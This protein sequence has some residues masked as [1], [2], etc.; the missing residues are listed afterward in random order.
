MI[1][2]MCPPVAPAGI[3]ADDL[4][5]ANDS[6]VQ[7]ARG[8]WQTRISLGDASAVIVDPGSATA[9]VTD[10]RAMGMDAARRRTAES[11]AA[12]T[13]AGVE[14]LFV[15]ID[16]TMRG[17]VAAQID[18]ALSIWSTVH[19]GAFAVV[20]PAYPA[21]GRTV[22]NGHLL[23]NGAGVE[24]TSVGRDPVTPVTTSDFGELLPGSVNVT[25]D[26]VDALVDELLRLSNAGTCIITV[27]AS[28]PEHLRMIGQAIQR[29]GPRAVPVGSAGLAMVMSVIWGAELFSP[30]EPP[31]AD[32]TTDRVV[33][34]LSSLHDMSR[35]QHADLVA[36]APD[37]ITLAPT[38]AEA[39]GGVGG[40]SR[41]D[42]DSDSDSS[43]SSSSSSSERDVT[44]DIAAWTTAQL[45]DSPSPVVVVLAPAERGALDLATSE[46]VAATLAAI[47]DEVITHHGAGSLV[48]MGGEG[49]R[50]VLDR[51]GA[52][53]IRVTRAIREGIPIGVI[54][55]GR[56]HG[57][58]VVTKAGGFGT[59]TSIT[60]IVP[61]LRASAQQ[62]NPEVFGGAESSTESHTRAG[63]IQSIAD[64][65]APGSTATSSNAPGSTATSSTAP[66]STIHGTAFS[67]TAPTTIH[68]DTTPRT[69]STEGERA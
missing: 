32:F 30:P 58:T 25:C 69:T 64:S 36:A 4:T 2:V 10:A 61:E 68:S 24:T 22:E 16:S 43:S 28:T 12:L 1:D 38:L 53:A 62:N 37:T 31:T 52:G 50:A 47:T 33:V 27:D 42:S 20:T 67:N 46:R 34:V 9:T 8:G 3:V 45:G 66:G 60:E 51:F 5:G 49:A 7:F 54:E 41:R 11:V 59:E 15:K 39:T 55:G 35:A 23:V 18:G 19:T 13:V 17:S 29:I 48:L 56:L 26:N 65:T 63:G 44:L 40:D 57:T 21:M 6:A 14:R